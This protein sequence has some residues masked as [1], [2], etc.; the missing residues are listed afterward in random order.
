[1]TRVGLQRH[2]KKNF[3]VPSLLTKNS[4]IIKIYFGIKITIND[5]FNKTATPFLSLCNATKNKKRKCGNSPFSHVYSNDNCEVIEK[6]RAVFEQVSN[7][8]INSFTSNIWI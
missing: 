8:F 6:V 7:V 4:K 3:G 1:M 5:N 2:R